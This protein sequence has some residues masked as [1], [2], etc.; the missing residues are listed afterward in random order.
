[1]F[2]GAL[3]IR[4]P[5]A[6]P[7][8]AAAA[9][10]VFLLS[11]GEVGSALLLCPPGKGALSV[12]IYNYLHYGATETVAGFCLILALLT[13]AVTGVSLLWFSR[14]HIA[15]VGNRLRIHFSHGGLEDRN[16]D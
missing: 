4:L 2:T 8:Y 14:G 5:L 7:G 13:L 16:F 11:M 1:M 6:A 9:G 12:K 15:H 10:I 3:R